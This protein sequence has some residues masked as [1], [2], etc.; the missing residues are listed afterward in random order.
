MAR[1]NATW[2]G[3]SEPGFTGDFEEYVA[4]KFA[5]SQAGDFAPL[6][7]GIV[8]EETYMEQGLYWE[9][10]YHPLMKYIL[11]DVQA[12]PRARRLPDDR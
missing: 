7:A 8:S 5:T 2:P 12:R 10:L 11:A 6:E 3:W 4:Q 1:A 9:T